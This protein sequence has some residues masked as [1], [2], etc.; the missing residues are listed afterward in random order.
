MKTI[1]PTTTYATTV[2][3]VCGSARRRACT[4]VHEQHQTITGDRTTTRRL[5]VTESSSSL[6][7][8][9]AGRRQQRWKDIQEGRTALYLCDAPAVGRSLQGLWG[10]ATGRGVARL[11]WTSISGHYGT[12]PSCGNVPRDATIGIHRRSTRN[13]RRRT[14]Q[15][16]FHQLEWNVTPGG[17]LWTRWWSAA[18]ISFAHFVR[19]LFTSAVG[20]GGFNSST[21]RVCVL[22]ADLPTNVPFTGGFELGM[23]RPTAQR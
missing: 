11:H 2:S 10:R 8:L 3:C 21:R 14:N 19:F 7:P 6:R 23:Q 15:T 4:R 9:S 5:K 17:A 16:E 20:T 13:G 1:I 22:I 12:A 18:R